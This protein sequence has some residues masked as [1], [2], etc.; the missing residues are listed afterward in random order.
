MD[1]PMYSKIR[2]SSNPYTLKARLLFER[3]Q[4]SCGLFLGS[5]PQHR[6]TKDFYPTCV[7]VSA[8]A[9]FLETTRSTLWW[10]WK[11]VMPAFPCTASFRL[12]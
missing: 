6:A 11:S 5:D 1:D 2:E 10:V 9:S 3:I 7:E 4:E 12:P 8:S